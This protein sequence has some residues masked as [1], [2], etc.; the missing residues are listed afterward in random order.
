MEKESGE[1]QV[2][3]NKQYIF[4][5]T[6]DF[7]VSIILPHMFLC[8][9]KIQI[10]KEYLKKIKTN[11]DDNDNNEIKGLVDAFFELNLN[12]NIESNYDNK[13]IFYQS[14]IKTFK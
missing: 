6:K 9:S 10:L 5:N 7:L 2:D 14:I 11:K 13:Y 12:N 3:F 4:Q 1:I 8:L